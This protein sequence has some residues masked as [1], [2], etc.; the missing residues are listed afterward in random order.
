[1]WCINVKK[2]TFKVNYLRT[3]LLAS[4]LFSCFVYYI[5]MIH[6]EA[7]TLGDIIYVC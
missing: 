5:L 6:F 4:L 2:F 3:R 1:M 7:F